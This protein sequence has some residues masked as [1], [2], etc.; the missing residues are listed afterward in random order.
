MACKK[1]EMDILSEISLPVRCKPLELALL[2]PVMV[3][4]PFLLLLIWH[5]HTGTGLQVMHAPCMRII[6]LVTVH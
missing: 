1:S 2:V 6:L 3:N 4:L 5:L